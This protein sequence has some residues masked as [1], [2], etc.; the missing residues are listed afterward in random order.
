[1]HAVSFML[2][3]MGNASTKTKMFRYQYLQ[4]F[5]LPKRMWFEPKVCSFHSKIF[6]GFCISQYQ[7]EVVRVKED[8]DGAAEA[9]VVAAAEKVTTM[10]M[11]VMPNTLTFIFDL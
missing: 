1:M 6:H 7:D 11:M 10:L 8:G 9:D 4:Y 5:M 3:L 2:W